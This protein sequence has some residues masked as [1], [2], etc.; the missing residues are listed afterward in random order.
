MQ[1][2]AKH[3]SGWISEVVEFIFPPRCT[4]CSS[5]D[6]EDACGIC[7]NCLQGVNYIYSPLCSICGRKFNTRD[8]VDYIC[9]HCL[10]SP[11]PY[12]IARS[13]AFY[14]EPV[15]KLLHNLKYRFDTTS[16][17]PLGKI[18]Q[19]FDFSPFQDCDLILPVP[20][21]TAKLKKRGMNQALALAHLFFLPQKK[22]INATVLLRKRKTVSQTK[23]D[24]V[25][26]K[27]NM[28]AAFEV[29]HNDI[30]NNKS[31]CLVDDV[32]TTGTTAEECAAA[33]VKAGAADIR[34]LTMARVRPFH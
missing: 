8:S 12:S 27:R 4:I 28:K 14:E 9:E 6:M 18:A 19:S 25:G 13:V 15:R 5:F 26:R 17:A 16:L 23:F 24:L 10:R 32:F 20:L 1:G 11:P 34:V 30:I 31:I 21:H 22:K 29:Q 2:I 33:L 3:M 7:R